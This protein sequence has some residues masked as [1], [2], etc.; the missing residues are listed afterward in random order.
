MVVRVLVV[1]SMCLDSIIRDE[2]CFALMR[3][4]CE[5]STKLKH[6]SCLLLALCE[7]IMLNLSMCY[8]ENNIS[9]YFTPN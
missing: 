3:Q 4:E 2:K 9:Q 7:L 6:P 1:K 5:L 8:V